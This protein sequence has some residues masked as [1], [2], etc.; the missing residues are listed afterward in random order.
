MNPVEVNSSF[1]H[2]EVVRDPQ[3]ARYLFDSI[4]HHTV[5]ISKVIENDNYYTVET[6]S[7]G[8]VQAPKKP[9]SSDRWYFVR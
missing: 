2:L 5:R 9:T 1:S 8:V 4:K 6:V 7:S 3:K